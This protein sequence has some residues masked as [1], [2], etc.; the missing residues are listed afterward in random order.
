MKKILL[1]TT[2]AMF[3]TLSFAQSP[4]NTDRNSYNDCKYLTYGNYNTLPENSVT[5]PLCNL[6]FFIQHNDLCKVAFYTLERLRPEDISGNEPRDNDFREDVRLSNPAR[7]SDYAKSGYDRGHLAPAGDFTTGSVVMSQSFLLSNMVPQNPTHNRRFWKNFEGQVRNYVK[8]NGEMVI[9]TGPVFTN[10]NGARTIGNS[11][12]VPDK[13]F[14]VI[15]NPNSNEYMAI[16]SDNEIL[17]KS[18]GKESS[19]S[20]E[21][22]ETLTGMVF[23]PEVTKKELK[24]NIKETFFRK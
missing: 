15:I 19:V 24:N 6:A 17:P 21:E 7:N 5:T 13:I 16:I 23:F 20:I 4:F 18:I 1:A 14:K 8:N 2:F 3:S 10:P 22:L 11:V 12:C 9:L